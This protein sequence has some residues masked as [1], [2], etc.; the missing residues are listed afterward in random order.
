M[1]TN[2]TY[3]WFTFESLSGYPV[4]NISLS[5]NHER[6]SA[7]QYLSS[8]MSITLEGLIY[9]QRM[10]NQDSS[11]MAGSDSI[12]TLFDKA[13]SLKQHIINN[14]TG[15]LKIFCG[16][17]YLVSGT[18]F[19]KNIS[20][21]QNDNHWTNSINYKIELS[22]PLTGIMNTGTTNN[23]HYHVVSV[24]DDYQIEAI[25]D[26]MYR[27]NDTLYLPT[28][29]ITRTIGAKG[30]SVNNSGAIY[31]AKQWVLQREAFKPITGIFKPS[32][33]PLYNQTR[34]ISVA[35]VEGSYTIS[36][37]F[38]SKSGDPWID[39]RSISLST[40]NNGLQQ[41]E[42]NGKIQG[43][44]RVFPAYQP[45]LSYTK[46]NKSVDPT[47]GV[48]P[49][50]NQTTTPSPRSYKYENAVS[51]YMNHINVMYDQALAYYKLSKSYNQ[52][53]GTPSNSLVLNPIPVSVTE[54][55]NPTE[56]SISYVRT[57][58]NRPICLVS[59]A[60][61]ENISIRESNPVESYAEI[62]VVGRRLGPVLVSNTFNKGVGV[63]TIS[64]EGVF[65]GATGLKKYSFPNN[66]RQEINKFISGLKPPNPSIIKE[67]TETLNL[68]ENRI[69]RT[70]SWEYSSC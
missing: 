42:I 53:A 58:N 8:E 13:Y 56:G 40:D 59:G 27:V 51:G 34:N 24:Q 54:G 29:R 65:P 12:K 44:E 16:S 61:S 57:Y 43:L 1:K 4:P 3:G 70:V 52:Y 18:G 30:K 47:I 5:T 50:S 39:T 49:V 35:E 23:L 22:V 48:L 20:F 63:K 11:S 46:D 15:L 62:F 67:D 69:A 45:S 10:A 21:D 55:M 64:Y 25:D 19:L 31:N 60:L 28:Y 41:I 66:I 37:T 9:T 7:G 17:S 33:F 14:N 2:I 68:I 26:Q 32:E 6:T 36:D 38:I